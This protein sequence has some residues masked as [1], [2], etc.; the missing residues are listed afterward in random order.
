M[1][2][3]RPTE[4]KYDSIDGLYEY[5]KTIVQYK[6][7]VSPLTLSHRTLGMCVDMEARGF[8][9]KRYQTRT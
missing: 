6:R 4:M 3:L 1:S 5:V 7:I 2:R 9:N 8:P